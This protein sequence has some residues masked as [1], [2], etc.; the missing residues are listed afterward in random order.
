M[1]CQSSPVSVLKSTTKDFLS[2]S[3]MTTFPR[4]D[5]QVQISSSICNLRSLTLLVYHT[6]NNRF[7]RLSYCLPEYGVLVYPL[8]LTPKHLFIVQP[9]D[10]FVSANYARRDARFRFP[11]KPTRETFIFGLHSARRLLLRLFRASFPFLAHHS[12]SV[13]F[14]KYFIVVILGTPY[15]FRVLII[16]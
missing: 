15:G 13:L 1:S 11:F 16:T 14:T 7:F 5:R 9:F 2:G 12:H 4:P 3:R 8:T 6:I 10:I